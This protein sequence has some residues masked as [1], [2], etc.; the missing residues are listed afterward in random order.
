MRVPGEEYYKQ[1]EMA[2]TKA[3][4][5]KALGV[6]EAQEESLCSWSERASG[7][8]EVTE[9]D[10]G[11]AEVNVWGREGRAEGRPGATFKDVALLLHMR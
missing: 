3:W 6:F 9:D 5:R 4:G 7:S 8:L 10:R 1:R 2:S 11:E